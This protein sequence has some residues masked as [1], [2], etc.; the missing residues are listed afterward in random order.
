MKF[1]IHYLNGGEDG[2]AQLLA[3]PSV[4]WFKAAA[5]DRDVRRNDIPDDPFS[6]WTT[7]GLLRTAQ[8]KGCQ[9]IGRRI[10]PDVT[11][12]MGA[13]SPGETLDAYWRGVSVDNLSFDE[14]AGMYPMVTHWESPNEP[15]VGSL[16]EMAWY[17]QF[18]AGFA[19]R[20]HDIGK[21]AIIGNWSVG[22]P[23]YPLWQAYGP[24]L[25]AVARGWAVLGRHNYGPIDPVNG[26]HYA[27]RHQ[28]DAAHFAQLNPAYTS[29][30]VVLTECGLDDI[31]GICAP[32]KDTYGDNF[33]RYWNSYL[34]PFF[35]VIEQ[36]STVLAAAVFTCGNGQADT[37]ER[38]NIAHDNPAAAI[39]AHPPTVV[40]VVVTPPPVVVDPPV[41]E[42]PIVVVDGAKYRV[43]K[44]TLYTLEPM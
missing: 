13:K 35:N 6:P 8:A 15:H 39:S 18:L 11:F 42:P 17:A 43:V 29:L 19:Q 30:P 31:P 28:T 34:L 26:P 4:H 38:R 41:T 23:D 25:E 44:T 33:D 9:I 3:L 40:P 7:M 10:E 12:S 14:L 5:L 20:M 27:Y 37:W 36:D 2:A 16:S 24:A 32:Y 1:A 22:Y 21:V